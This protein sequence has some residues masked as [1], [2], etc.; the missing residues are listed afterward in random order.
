MN[1]DIGNAG[2]GM[3]VIVD[4]HIKANESYPVFAEGMQLQGLNESGNLSNIFVQNADDNGTYYGECWPGNS[5]WIDFLNEN[6]QNFWGQWFA[7]DKFNMSNEIYNFW[8]DMNE[9]SVFNTASGTLPMDT[10]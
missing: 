1:R 8:N 4:P 7:Y 2:R 9:P 3:V 5:S 6:A 10:L